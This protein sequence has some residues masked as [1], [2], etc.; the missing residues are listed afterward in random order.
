TR[1][2]GTPWAHLAV[3]TRTNAQ[4]VLLEESLRAARIPSWVSGGEAFLDR[5]EIRDALDELRGAPVGM[6]FT[7]RLADL[8][9]RVVE[10]G[11]AGPGGRPDDRPGSGG[12]PDG[13]AGP[14]GRPD[15][16]ERRSHLQGLVRPRRE[17]EPADPAAAAD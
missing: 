14:G 2:P 9:A 12:R 16:E 17:D 5:P 8:E 6:P 11:T 3:L 7:A 15:E 4:L 13:T 10:A 1:R